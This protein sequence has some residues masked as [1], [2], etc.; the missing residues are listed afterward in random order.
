MVWTPDGTQTV[1]VQI[2]NPSW[3]GATTVILVTDDPTLLSCI[4][5]RN[6]LSFVSRY[7]SHVDVSLT[8][9]SS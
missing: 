9:S 6:P 2:S 8:K 1:T 3:D 5:L 7:E 4:M